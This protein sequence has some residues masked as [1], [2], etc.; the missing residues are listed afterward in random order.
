[1]TLRHAALSTL[2]SAALLLVACSP[3]ESTLDTADSSTTGIDTGE[4]PTETDTS[5]DPFAGLF[6]EIEPTRASSDGAPPLPVRVPLTGPTADVSLPTTVVL[7]GR[8]TTD[9]VQPLL[10]ALAPASRTTPARGSLTFLDTVSGASFS[11]PFDDVGGF[12]L[13]L[14]AGR[15][16]VGLHAEDAG[17]APGSWA[18]LVAPA[19]ED[20]SRAEPAAASYDEALDAGAPLYGQILAAGAQGAGL[21]GVVY[22]ISADGTARTASQRIGGAGDFELRVQ[23]GTWDLVVDPDDPYAPTRQI[24]VTLDAAGTKASL[25][26][27][28]P[29]T[30]PFRAAYTLKGVAI[31]GATVRVRALSL[32]GVEAGSYQTEGV[33]DAKGNFNAPLPYGRY[34]VELVAAA[35]APQSAWW[36]TVDVGTTGETSVDLG[37]IDVAPTLA[38]QVQVVDGAGSPVVGAQLRFEEGGTGYRTWFAVTDAQ[39]RGQATASAARSELVVVPPG[40]RPDLAQVRIRV[41]GGALP[42]SV[43]LDAGERVAGTI[44]DALGAPSGYAAIR[45]VDAAGR[46]YALGL[47]DL[48]GRFS[49]RFVPPTPVAPPVQDTA[50]RETGVPIDTGG[51]TPTR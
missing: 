19:I 46:S 33:T 44:R 28:A 45:I 3:S 38:A 17:A 24:R 11:A 7:D 51:P 20:P 34:A 5:T 15:W 10:R 6:L 40:D 14:P 12:S 50:Q 39:G 35:G 13:A 47:T 25:V 31:V 8:W 1:M 21:D 42:T 26:I 37:V 9:V 18:T 36:T 30:V 4:A 32:V 48:E 23:P 27:P 49:L 43:T 29:K 22:A 2:T 16:T 41:E